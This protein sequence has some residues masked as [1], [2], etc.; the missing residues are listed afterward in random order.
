MVEDG[1]V[2]ELLLGNKLRAPLHVWDLDKP[3]PRAGD[4]PR[5]G[6]PDGARAAAGARPVEGLR[7][8]RRGRLDRGPLGLDLAVGARR[9]RHG[10]R[11]EG[12]HDPGR[13]GRRRRAARRSSSRFGAVP[14]LIT[15]IA[16]SVDDRSLYVSCWGTGELKRFDVTRPARAA[17]DRLRAA[18]RDR[19]AR[20]R[21]RR[22][23]RSTAGRRWWRS[24]AT[25]AASTS[26]TRS[27]RAW[28]AQ[29]YPEGID[30]WL[31]KLDAG[32]DGGLA[33]DPD[34][35]R[36]VPRASARTRCAC[37]A[38]TPRPTPSASRTADGATLAAGC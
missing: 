16:L 7:L 37:R 2:G 12:H 4:R 31:V 29:F 11:G 30:G 23:A 27:T 22:P 19:R 25:G 21:T 10:R 28:D 3:P 5:R 33:L 20:R 8:R 38:A 24:A 18:R 13:A 26:R 35:L 32:E 9:G 34:A 1:I 17:G 36:R 15:D 6:A 14:P